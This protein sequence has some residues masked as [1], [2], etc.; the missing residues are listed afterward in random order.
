LATDFWIGSGIVWLLIY[1]SVVAHSHCRF[2]NW[3]RHSFWLLI[4]ESVMTQFL[5]A[6]SELAAPQFLAVDFW[7]GSYL[8]GYRFL[9]RQLHS[10]AADLWVISGIVLAADLWV[11]SGAV[12]VA[13]FLIGSDTVF[14]CWFLNRQR[15]S[16][17]LPI[18]ESAAA[19]FLAA[20]LWIGSA[21]VLG[22]RS[23][24]RQQPSSRC[25]FSLWLPISESAATL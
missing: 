19:K 18:S 12:L 17:W 5:A 21:T 2:L 15:C 22:C 20:H 16:F 13:D 25:R 8:V 14:G 9:N 1:E 10:L 11:S 6:V 23:L 7:F 24:N 3:Q 4:S